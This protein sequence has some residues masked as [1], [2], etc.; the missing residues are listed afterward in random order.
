[1]VIFLL[2]AFIAGVYYLNLPRREFDITCSTTIRIRA[3]FKCLKLIFSANDFPTEDSTENPDENPTTYSIDYYEYVNRSEINL[4]PP[5]NP[6]VPLQLP[7]KR[8]IIAH[9]A[10]PIC[11]DF[12]IEL[13]T[14]K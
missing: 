1:M 6:L 2:S 8:V 10:T 4:L 7:V 11:Q 9:T 12:V 5:E 3:V 13:T 14:H